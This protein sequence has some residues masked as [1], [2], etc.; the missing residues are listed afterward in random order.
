MAATGIATDE[1]GHVRTD[2]AYQTNVAGI[3][4]IGDLANHFQLKHMVNAEAR[5]VRLV[6][7]NLVHPADQRRAPF[8]VVAAAIFAGPQVASVGATERELRDAERPYVV[9][10]RTTGTPHTAGRSRTPP[11]S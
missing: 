1:H 5:L 4:A 6:R 7:H 3:F 11:G 10:T 9:A 8:S 2:S